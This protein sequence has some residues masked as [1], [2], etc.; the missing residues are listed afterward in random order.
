MPRALR[1]SDYMTIQ[2][3]DSK[4]GAGPAV[5]SAASLV[6]KLVEL[7]AQTMQDDC[8]CVWFTTSSSL[9]SS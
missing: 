2:V 6:L 1:E 8:V 9:R 4:P 7:V 3:W 5:N